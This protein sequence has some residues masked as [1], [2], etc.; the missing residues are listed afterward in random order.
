MIGIIGAME[1]EVSELTAAM[2]DTKMYEKAGMKFVSGK[3]EGTPA[4]VVRSGVGKVN[5]AVCTQILIDHF[6]VTAVINT[7]I[8]GAV[9]LDVGIGDIVLSTS[10]LQHDMGA[11]AF[12]Y[13]LGV[14]PQQSCSDFPADPHLLELAQ[15]CCAELLP[16]ANVHTGRVV[17]G[18]VFVAKKEQKTL[19]RQ[20]FDALCT[21]MEGAAIA[22]TAWLNDLPY[23]VV[24]AISDNADA[25]SVEDYPAFEREAAARSAKLVR[26]MLRRLA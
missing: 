24:R 26:N 5:A 22:H 9:G 3:L 15:Q 13:D 16:E 20:Q 1:L 18:D 4:V 10:A 12:G 21:E 11:V 8:A 23:L 2:E 14:I 25:A 6:E 19:L 7:G 17:T